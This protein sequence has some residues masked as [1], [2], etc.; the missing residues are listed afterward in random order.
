MVV[1]GVLALPRINKPNEAR[2]GS[3]ESEWVVEAVANGET[4]ADMLSRKGEAGRVFHEFLTASSAEAVRPLVR[5]PGETV[6]LIRKIRRLPLFSPPPPPLK[7]DN[8]GAY[9]NQSLTY[10]ILTGTLPDHSKFETYFT[11]LD[12]RL[13]M[14]W[15]AST[16]CGTATFAQ[17]RR[18]QGDPAEIR[19]WIEPVEFYSLAFSENSHQAYQLASPDKLQVIWTYARRGSDV[20]QALKLLIKGGYIIKGRTEPQKVTVRLAPGPADSLPGQWQIVELL[21]KEWISP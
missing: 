13:V 19:G 9:E 11:V 16:A 15:K 2:P 17:L 20:H 6:G 18:N 3:G 7:I 10:G 4:M 8:W 5:D 1:G 14:D 21:H 12:G